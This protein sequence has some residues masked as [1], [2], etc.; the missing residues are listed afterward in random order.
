MFIVNSINS[1]ALEDTDVDSISELIDDAEDYLSDS[2]G[3][4]E[5]LLRWKI[6]LHKIPALPHGY[7]GSGKGFPHYCLRNCP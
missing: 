4:E 2:A 1:M 3:P 7:P 6:P 5:Y